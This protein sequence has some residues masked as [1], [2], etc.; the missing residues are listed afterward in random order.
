MSL[1]DYTKLNE[2]SPSAKKILDSD[3]LNKEQIIYTA[4]IA[5]CDYSDFNR[6]GDDSSMDYTISFYL[7]IIT[8]NNEDYK[9][10]KYNGN[11]II[12]SLYKP[13]DKF[14]YLDSEEI[15]YTEDIDVHTFNDIKNE[16]EYFWDWYSI[17]KKSE[18]EDLYIKMKTVAKVL[19]KEKK[20]E[21]K[22]LKIN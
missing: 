19:W 22:V 7:F 17:C 6:D 8:K 10:Y 12:V 13:S 4:E 2:L 15:K 14:R 5:N 9:F 11:T 3:F 18:N 1:Y 21:K 20:L 16:K